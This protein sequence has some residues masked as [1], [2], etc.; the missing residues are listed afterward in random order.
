[1]DELTRARAQR[2]I[3][4]GQGGD[5]ASAARYILGEMIDDDPPASGYIL[6]GV[7]RDGGR[8]TSTRIGRA[9][10]PPYE[11]VGVLERAKLV[12]F[13][14]DALDDMEAEQ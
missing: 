4:T 10:M 2:A 8:I 5:P 9:G 3:E 11:V 12:T 7:W 1:M 13:L 6:I 14:D